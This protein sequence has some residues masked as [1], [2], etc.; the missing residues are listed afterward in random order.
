[1]KKLVLLTFVIAFL[2]LSAFAEGEA[3][4]GITA[5]GFKAGLSMSTLTGDIDGVKAK[6]GFAGGAFLTYN[7]SP[8]MAVQPEVIYCMKGVKAEV[9]DM[10]LKLDYLVIP[11]LLKYD[12]PTQGKISPNIFAGPELGILLSAKKGD[13]DIKDSTESVDFGIS[14]GAGIDF[15]MESGKIT[16]DARYTVGLS[17]V[18]KTEEGDNTSVKNGTFMVLLGYGF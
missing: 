4:K 17:N 10:K 3:V 6:A 9:G 2:A 18:A 13:V 11:V 14:F 12:V 5:K 1:M 16:L 8:A 7:F 15:A